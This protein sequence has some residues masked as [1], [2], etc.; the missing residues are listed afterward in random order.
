MEGC[1]SRV[2]G[3]GFRGS[4]FQGLTGG[5]RGF[6]FW[7]LFWV[8]GFRFLGSRFVVQGLTGCRVENRTTRSSET[9]VNKA[10]GLGFRV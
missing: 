10:W 2:W 5:F 9:G 6:G 7:G 8:S 4:R 1:K 3:F